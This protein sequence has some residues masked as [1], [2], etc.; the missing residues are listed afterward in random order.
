MAHYAKGTQSPA[1]QCYHRTTRAPTACKHTVSGSISL[2]SLAS[3]SPFP[4]GTCPLSVT[5][6]YL[7]LGGG[8]PGFPQ[9][10]SGPAVLGN[11]TQGWLNISATGLSP[12]L[13]I[14]S[15]TFTYTQSHHPGDSAKPPS[16]A[17]Q[18]RTT[19]ASRLPVI[20]FGLFPFR[21]PLLRESR[22]LSFPKGT[23]MF[24]FPSLAAASYEF[25]YGY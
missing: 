15:S 20:R 5:R 11:T 9:G 8:P 24:Q 6:E 14:R 13:G 2:A 1:V 25:R 19:N 22:L 17:P 3:F 10:F 18:H 7:V 4:H 16:N 23:K 12:S 21:S